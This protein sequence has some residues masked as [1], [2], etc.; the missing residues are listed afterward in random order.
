MY[1]A[2]ATAPGSEHV[3]PGQPGKSNNQDAIASFSF[4]RGYVAVLCDGCSESPRSETGA[5]I[6]AHLIAR[7]IERQL[8]FVGHVEAIDW[9]SILNEVIS[10]LRDI[11]PLFASGGEVAQ[12][13]KAV[14]ERFLFTAVV[15][16]IMDGSAIVALLGDGIV[17]IDDE[18]KVPAP[19]ITNS[20][21]Y[22]GYLLL[23]ASPYHDEQY[24]GNLA[25]QV[26]AR[27][28]LETL[29]KGLIVAT[30]GLRYLLDEDIHHPALVQPKSLQRWLNVQASERMDMNRGKLIHGKCADD[31]SLVVI[32]S[33]E[34]QKRLIEGRQK[35]IELKERF[36]QF[37]D[38]VNALRNELP[39]ILR[40]TAEEKI[41]SLEHALNELEEDARGTENFQKEFSAFQAN[42]HTLRGSIENLREGPFLPE[43]RVYDAYP[44]PQD[45]PVYRMWSSVWEQRPPSERGSSH[46]KKP[47]KK[48]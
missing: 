29:N 44:Y 35:S 20:P 1:I 31:V 18:V 33:E 41:L 11:V 13:E 10:S 28:E 21:A 15:L 34:A 26:I 25:F 7:A 2:I 24:K 42:V 22:M 5:D 19:P 6:G 9:G 39:V 16:V 47:F 45:V 32:R 38:R 4:N 17:I 30:D 3:N 36:L 46:T 14:L 48:K 23:R 37:K 8:V 12:F 27:V 40:V 43:K